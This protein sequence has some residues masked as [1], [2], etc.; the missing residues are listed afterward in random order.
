MKELAISFKE[1]VRSSRKTRNGNYWL[2]GVIEGLGIMRSLLKCIKISINR[3]LRTKN[4]WSF[5][6]WCVK[7]WGFLMMSIRC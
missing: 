7:R 5:W 6:C 2:L 3:T 4:V 1:H